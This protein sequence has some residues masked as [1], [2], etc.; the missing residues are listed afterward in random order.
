MKHVWGKAAG[1]LAGALALAVLAGCVGDPG[2]DGLS[3]P[4]VEVSRANGE[5]MFWAGSC[6]SCHGSE[7]RLDSKA[8]RLG[9]GHAMPTGY[10]VFRAPNISPD[11]QHGMGNWTLAEFDRA[12]RQGV[13]PD[14]HSYYPAF[15]YPSYARMKPQDIA[16]LYAYIM[17]LPPV[18]DDAEG[19][20]LGLVTGQ[21]M[22]AR[23][24]RAL[25]PASGPAVTLDNPSPQVAR[26]QYL[27]EGPGHCGSCHTPRGPLGG[28]R[29]GR[30]LAGAE[31]LDGSGYAPN[32]TPHEDG[33]EGYSAE[34]IIETLHP[35]GSGLYSGMEAARINLSHLPQS[36]IEAI[37]AYLMA[38]PPRR[39][40][41]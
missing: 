4:P 17:T 39:S 35:T 10:G 28:E 40:A 14:G 31:M 9:G 20:D 32:L 36:D 26:G 38:L 2:Q 23:G 8:P 16:D 30:W 5:A 11:P 21:P 15:P 33:L 3:Q 27:V 6:A 22:A 25:H 41:E 12:M 1:G 29:A 18:S 34:E 7:G 13:A 19:N 37:A 24:W